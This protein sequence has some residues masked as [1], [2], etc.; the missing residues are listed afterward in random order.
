MNQ[1]TRQTMQVFDIYEHPRWG[2]K[3]VKRGFSWSAFLA[4]SV[5]AAARGLGTLTLL[6]VVCSTLMFDLLKLAAGFVPDPVVMLTLFV[7][8]YLAFG[9]KPGLRGNAWHAAKLIQD[10]FNRKFSVAAASRS[11]AL[12][13]VRAGRVRKAPDLLLANGLTA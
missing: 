5:W 13:A 2:L 1:N 10:G 8:A 11:Q 6:L 7:V 12:S 3:A 9:I 4:P